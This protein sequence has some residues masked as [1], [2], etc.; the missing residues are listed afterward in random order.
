M[1]R[2]KPAA[3]GKSLIGLHKN[4]K[5][6]AT[7]QNIGALQGAWMTDVIGDYGVWNDEWCW[8]Y[9][10]FSHAGR[11]PAYDKDQANYRKMPYTFFLRQWLWGISQGGRVS[12]A[13]LPLAF[14][15]EGRT[16]LELFEIPPSVHQRNRR[17]PHPA[18]AGSR[19]A[20]DPGHRRSFRGLSRRPKD[21]G[22]TTPGASSSPGW[23]SR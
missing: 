4:T 15:R 9:S 13:E 1:T 18:L 22:S 11:F 16:K 19:P 8:T 6:W 7:M 23:T 12:F 17:A 5:P 3:M 21:P 20:Q 10:S 14:D 2:S